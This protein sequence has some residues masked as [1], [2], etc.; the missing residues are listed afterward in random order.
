M[1]IYF[2]IVATAL[3]IVNTTCT[4]LAVP[5]PDFLFNVGAQV[6][7][8]FSF[9]AVLLSALFVGFRQY[10]KVF[11]ISIKH[12]K[13]FWIGS[14]VVVMAV[15]FAGSYFYGQYSQ[16]IEYEKWVAESKIQDEI[17]PVTDYSIDKL[18][19]ARPTNTDRQAETI[20]EPEIIQPEIP[21]APVDKN[22][23]FIKTYYQ[24]IGQ[25]N[26]EAA[27]AVSK[28]QVPFETFEEWYQDTDAASVED[29]QKIDDTNYSLRIGLAEKG[30]ITNYGVLMT[31]KTDELGAITIADSK[32][33][34]LSSIPVDAVNAETPVAVIPTLENSQTNDEFFEN[35]KNLALDITNEDFQKTITADSNIFVLD[36]R[37]D[38]E[39]GIGYFPGSTHIKFADLVAGEWIKLPTDRVIYVFCW[40]GIRGKEVAMFL[41]EK[42]IVARYVKT[43]ADGWVTFGGKWN[44]GIKFAS[45]YTASQYSYLFDLDTL[46]QKMAE[47]VAVVDSRIANKYAT[48]HIPGS[49]N[50]PIIYTPTSKIDALM[51]QVPSGAAVIT[52]C[53]DFVS[54]FDAK[55]TGLKLEKR[56]HVFLGRYNKPWEYRYNQ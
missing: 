11:Y 26:L 4:A 17:D 15:S 38:E 8:A 55:I 45:K 48:W 22:E 6:A 51:A 31:L 9:I 3:L 32:S 35:N 34:V 5:P 54:C 42:Q 33:R 47:G 52:V 24:N 40:S 39:Y 43:G 44:G 1:K 12:K 13:L 18:K 29:I 56:G 23:E 53:D 30:M 27:Y 41:R 7:Q 37:E 16:N 25:G 28:K 46:K 20:V 19:I 36:A 49:I 21:A 2:L 10:A 50:I 14:A